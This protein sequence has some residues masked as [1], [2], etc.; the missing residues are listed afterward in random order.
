LLGAQTPYPEPLTA[1]PWPKIVK[2]IEHCL[3][4]RLTKKRIIQAT[5][6]GS[7]STQ[8]Y[9]LEIGHQGP[10]RVDGVT[11][12]WLGLVVASRKLFGPEKTCL[13]L[14]RPDRKIVRAEI[15]ES[16]DEKD[17]I[18][19]ESAVRRNS[20]LTV[21]GSTWWYGNGAHFASRAF[22]LSTKGVRK[23]GDLESVDQGTWMTK[24]KLRKGTIPPIE[25][26]T[27]TYPKNLSVPR[28]YAVFEFTERW[29]FPSG[30]PHRVWRRKQST[31]FNALDDVYG[32]LLRRHWS[33]VRRMS[34]SKQVAQQL[35]NLEVE[36]ESPVNLDDW[37]KNDLG[38]TGPSVQLHFVDRGGRWLVS[39]VKHAKFD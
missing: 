25:V 20:I 32:A 22:Q 31:K 21:A 23:V 34:T 30:C 19:P 10:V 26:R 38:L 7:D 27:R 3:G 18:L 8:G 36:G 13:V 29:T 11:N 2:Q 16:C 15:W 37:K 6:A 17:S 33:V 24:I 28:V 35:W 9:E 1:L 4:S 5:K 14:F 39:R 12:G